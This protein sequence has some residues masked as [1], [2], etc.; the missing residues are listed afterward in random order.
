MRFLYT[1]L[2]YLLLPFVF[3]RL[4]WRSRRL[5]EYRKRWLER[6]GFCSHRLDKSIWIHAVS[7]GESLA[8]IPLIKAIKVSYPTTP[9][10][11]TNMTPTGAARV[12][13]A[14]G[15]Q[16][17]QAY[18]PYDIPA[19]IKRFIKSIKPILLVVM[20]TE[21]WPNLFASCHAEHIPII[22]TNARLSEKSARGYA[23]IPFF[24]RIMFAAI[25]RLAAQYEAD[26]ARFVALG[27]PRE[28]VVVTGNL[29]FDV[30]VRDDLFIKSS[31]LRNELGQERLIWIAASTHLSEEKIILDAHKL[32]LKNNPTA[33]LILVPRHPERF[34]EVISLV[35]QEGLSTECRSAK[36]P[37]D[38]TIQVYVSDT[39]G[40]LMLMY[41]VADVALVA[42]S[43]VQVGGHNMLEAAVLHKPILTGP[44]LFNFAEVSQL[45]LDAGGMCIVHNAEEIAQKILAWFADE[46]L[47]LR[48]GENAYNVVAANRGALERQ[49]ALIRHIG[50]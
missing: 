6:L 48:V 12:R 32:I 47:R 42:G 26:A 37:I 11:V 43:F 36:K 24:N 23:R 25:H 34:V 39:M 46:N 38:E 31:A 3:I 22:V 49:L 35:K 50:G 15:D 29:K 44:V 5:P 41:A 8:A 27:L 9:I 4:L 13:A 45:L 18:V 33:L 20:E 21:L 30:E 28:K 40:E 19:F 1:L 14:L 7:V 10:V 16:V 2:F 17:I